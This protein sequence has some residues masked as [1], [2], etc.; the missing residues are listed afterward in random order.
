[1]PTLLSCYLQG[2]GQLNAKTSAQREE[3]PLPGLFLIT[4]WPR[5]KMERLPCIGQPRKAMRRWLK[6][7]KAGADIKAKDKDGKTPLY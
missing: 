3:E 4:V 6:L 5:T 7:L 2:C 1:M